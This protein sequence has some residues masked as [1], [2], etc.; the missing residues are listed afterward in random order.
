MKNKAII[1]FTIFLYMT[2]W[3]SAHSVLDSI[4]AEHYQ[5]K[6]FDIVIFP[7]YSPD[8]MPSVLRFTPTKEEVDQAEDA[9]TKQLPAL[10]SDKQNQYETPIID[11]HLPK[12]KRQYFGYI[13]QNGNRILLINCFWRKDKDSDLHWLHE[14]INVLDGGSYYWNV[15]FNLKKNELFDLNVNGEA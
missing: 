12:Y 1:L 10:N 11:K 8:L 7:E 14:K 6:N 15:K 4:N 2:L 3:C 9:L 5:T 13:D